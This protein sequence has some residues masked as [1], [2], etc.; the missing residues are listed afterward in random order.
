MKALI[1]MFLALSALS[2]AHAEHALMEGGRSANGRYE[3][4][5]SRVAD[6]GDRLLKRA[7]T[8]YAIR[9]Y[10]TRHSKSLHTLDSGGHL[11]YTAAVE[12]CRAIWHSSNRFVAISDQP[13]R[14]SQEFFVLDVSKE[15]VRRFELPDYVQNA[16][17][18]VNATEVDSTCVSTLKRWDG[19]DL[20]VELYF[21]AN[22][23]H[24]Y[25]CEVTFHLRG[26]KD[27][28]TY[29]EFKRVSPLKES[30]G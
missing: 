3:V 5:I 22:G 6:E 4:R 18:R 11:N 17:G 24:T 29:L 7:A 14:H 15:R 20:I 25:T 27:S 28:E 2:V 8:S 16:I 13:A 1:T 12:R 30:E 10:E 21:N 26:L 23:R 9:L 19:D